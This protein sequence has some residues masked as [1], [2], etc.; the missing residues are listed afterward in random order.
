MRVR[1]ITTCALGLAA[2]LSLANTLTAQTT[3]DTTK[4]RT[5]TSQTRINISKGEV[6]APRVD[7][8]YVT[9][10]DTV[11]NSVTR[12]DT[13]TVTP[14][15]PVVIPKVH[16]PMYWGLYAGS[17]W[18]TGNIDRV[19]TN[20]FHAGGV[21]GWEARHSPLGIRFDGSVAQLG[22]EFGVAE[23]SLTPV[24]YGSGTALLGQLGADAKLN[25]FQ[26]HG[27]NFYGIGGVNGYRYKRIALATNSD[28]DNVGNA[29]CDFTLR[30]SCYN[31][32]NNNNWQNAWGFNFGLGTDFHI[33]S[34]DMFLETRYMGMQKFDARTWTMPISLGVRFF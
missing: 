17:T 16:G 6:V 28:V 12:V 1:F 22:R 30:G 10:Y 4:L 23:S 31:N 3:T 2:A 34:Q 14:P 24:N 33:G 9:R 13:V 15:M 32:A 29:N 5:T 26:T 27:W 11:T 21:L 18:P 19:Y 8:V 7:T 25:V 20:G